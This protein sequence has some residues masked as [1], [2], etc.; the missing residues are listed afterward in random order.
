MSVKDKYKVDPEASISFIY[1]DIEEE[2]KV[3]SNAIGKLNT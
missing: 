1:S 2:D 3:V